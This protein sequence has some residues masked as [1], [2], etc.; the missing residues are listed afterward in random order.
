MTDDLEEFEKLLKESPVPAPDEK[1]KRDAIS[2]GMAAF[3]LKFSHTTQGTAP[4]SRLMDAVRTIH[5]TIL[6]RDFMKK[7]YIVAGLGLLALVFMHTGNVSDIVGLREKAAEKAVTHHKEAVVAESARSR[8][9]LSLS[10]GSLPTAPE[11]AFAAA[12]PAP[13]PPPASLVDAQEFAKKSGLD[14]AQ[15]AGR[16]K[17]L[18]GGPA[19]QQNLAADKTSESSRADALSI[20]PGALPAPA[21]SP[22]MAIGSFEAGNNAPYQQPSSY[23]N[24]GRDRFDSFKSNPV[25]QVRE[26]PVSTF[27]IDVNTSSYSFLRATL[28]RGA[29]PQADAVRAEELINYFPYAYETPASREEPFKTTVSV[30]PTPW[31]PDTKLLRIGIKGYQIAA[32]EKPHSNLVFLLDTSGSMDDPVRLPLVVNAM[33][34]LLDS[35]NPN[36]TVAVVTY[37]GSAGVALEPTQVKDKAKI[38]S[39]LDGLSAYGS[40]AGYDGLKTA[41]QLAEQHFD[42]RGVN[43][44]ILSTDGDFNVGVTDQSELRK[45]IAQE[46]DKGIF[47]SVLGV[48]M[49]N[50]NDA[51]MQAL[52]KSGNGV[53]AYIDNLNEARKVLVD[54]TSATL[55]TIA[56]DVKI[57]VEFNPAQVSEYRLIGYESGIL[58]REDFNNDKVEGGEVGAGHA[59]TALYEIT[60]VGSKSKRVDDLRYQKPPVA[61]EKDFGHGEYAFIKI[62]YKL[63]GENASRL[64][65]TPVD[66]RSEAKALSDAPQDAR[67][68]AAVAAFAQL[69]RGDTSLGTFT[70]DDVIA[71]ARAAR[72]DDMF[73]YRAEFINMVELAKHIAGVP[74]TRNQE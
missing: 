64:I 48:G 63:P 12:S 46:R 72:G 8:N 26:D 54:E 52:A 10:P 11:P 6:G 2:G 30:M 69:L 36:D 7:A 43:R 27:A 67:F 5:T 14:S 66:G 39:V 34:L 61:E 53:A 41:Y 22:P 50:Y 31:N 24:E 40:T 28:N 33:K 35:L 59:V 9:E 1:A 18:A 20:S 55:F 13:P 16:L 3:D 25:R 37:A 21:A 71:L 68:A 73:G 47:L 49:G 60:P 19:L 17:D 51:L 32:K 42:A 4:A 45:F 23:R 38:V 44:V 57:Q 58:N 74:A 29:L 70:Y 62:R 56:K 15:S 65:S